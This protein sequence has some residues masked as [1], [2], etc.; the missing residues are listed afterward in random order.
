MKVGIFKV[1]SKLDYL[2][3]YE[4]AVIKYLEINNHN[5]FLNKNLFTNLES[6]KYEELTK[7]SDIDVLFTIGGDGT[8]L[9]AIPFVKD[10][11]VPILGIN[12]GQLGFLT[13]LNKESLTKGLDM[14]FRKKFTLITKILSTF[15]IST[16]YF[17]LLER[18]KKK[19]NTELDPE[20]THICVA[21]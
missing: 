16:D 18:R 5:I 6:N 10:S 13:S 20:K 14:F 1:S 7:I 3:E 15:I 19:N 8:L 2:T 11:N 4:K 21:V 9:R 12:T 17:S